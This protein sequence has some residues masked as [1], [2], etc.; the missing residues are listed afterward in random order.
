MAASL[1]AACASRRSREISLKRSSC[2]ILSTRSAASRRFAIA[3]WD[4]ERVRRS[5]QFQHSYSHALSPRGFGLCA[6]THEKIHERFLF[7][8]FLVRAC[9]SPAVCSFCHNKSLTIQFRQ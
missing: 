5:H 3:R 8:S 4:F 6:F 1:S 9:R 2:S 7:L